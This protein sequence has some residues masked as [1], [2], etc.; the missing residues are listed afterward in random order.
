[1]RKWIY[2]FAVIMLLIGSAQAESKSMFDINVDHVYAEM[3]DLNQLENYLNSNDA[4]LSSLVEQNHYLVSNMRTNAYG[5]HSMVAMDGPP[6]GISSF[7]WGFCLGLPGLAVVYFVTED[8]AETRKALWGCITSGVL[9]G[10]FYIVW[11][12]LWA[13]STAWWY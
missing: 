13:S 8:S 3:A 2:F 6:L 10:G 9:I 11:Y 7:L 5:L 12:A 1:M 4:T